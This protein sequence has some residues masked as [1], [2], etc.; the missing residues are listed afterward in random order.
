MARD[1]I[2][3]APPRT[4]LPIGLDLTGLRVGVVGRDRQALNRLALLR[5][6][7]VE[8]VAVWS[9][10]P[11]PALVEQEGARLRHCLPRPDEVAGLALLF[12]ADLSEDEARPL[13]SMARAAGV[14]VNAEDIPPLCDFHVPAV[15]KRGD[16]VLSVSTRGQAPGL[17]GQI[18]RALEAQFDP[19]WEQRVQEVAS[20]RQAL[21]GDGATPPEIAGQVEAHVRDRGWLR[22]SPDGGPSVHG[23]R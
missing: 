18:R 1:R 4:I 10:A 13:A 16:L 7:A 14:L 12:V 23:G 9:D 17:A 22:G 11:S 19:A 20:L 5:K 15:V 2:H 21:R 6:F 8:D 3:P